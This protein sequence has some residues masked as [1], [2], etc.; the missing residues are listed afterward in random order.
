M[1]RMVLLAMLAGCAPEVPDRYL[2]VDGR[3]G[4]YGLEELAIPELDDPWRM[5]GSLGDGR[6]GGYIAGDLFGGELRGYTGG[7]PLRL[8]YTVRDG[9]GVPLDED[10][11]ILWSYYHTL[12]TFRGELEGVGFDTSGIFPV[13]FAY[14]PSLGGTILSSN[15]AYAG[16]VIHLFVLLPDG[17]GDG[18]PLAANPG[19]I[20]HEFGHAI[21]Q[22]VIGGGVGV[23]TPAIAL[24]EVSALNEGFADMVATLSLDDPD[25]ITPSI[26]LA[27]T[28]DVTGDHAL[29]SED[30][31]T[32]P[33]S[34]GTVYASFT[35]DVRRALDDREATLVHVLATLREWAADAPWELGQPGVDLFPGLLADRVLADHPELEGTLCAAYDARFPGL[36]RPSACL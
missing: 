19:V 8:E 28:R 30:P 10:G 3:E 15:A 20:R 1:T 32:N 12:S 34:R 2:V 22:S 31:A 33:Y 23:S 14:Q 27:G 24:P 17:G 18:L 26:D 21:F 4:V 16:D 9:T 7:A 35:W 11:V 25:F 6:V 13:P 29:P 5:R 36:I